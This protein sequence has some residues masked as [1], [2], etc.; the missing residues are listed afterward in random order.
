MYLTSRNAL[1]RERDRGIERTAGGWG[2]RRKEVS[3]NVSLLGW[4][5]YS[6]HAMNEV[7]AGRDRARPASVRHVTTSSRGRWT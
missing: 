4:D 5:V 2:R 7:D 3:S 6:K 1:G